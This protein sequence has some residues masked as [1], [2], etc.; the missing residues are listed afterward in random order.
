MTDILVTLKFNKTFRV[1]V[2]KYYYYAKAAGGRLGLVVNSLAW[3]L[4][5]PRFKS[6]TRKKIFQQEERKTNCAN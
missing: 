4:G 6:R 3:G 2:F 5:S 1:L